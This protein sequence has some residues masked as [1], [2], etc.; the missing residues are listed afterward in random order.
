METSRESE[1]WS[2]KKE[3]D[4]GERQRAG[5]TGGP[6]SGIGAD[7]GHQC[8]MGGMGSHSGK[9]TAP[10]AG[11][12]ACHPLET[13]YRPPWWLLER[14]PPTQ[15]SRGRGGLG[16]SGSSPGDIVA[17]RWGY[18]DGGDEAPPPRPCRTAFYYWAAES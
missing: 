8:V 6:S 12:V 17:V 4:V 9:T 10:G 13:G 11:R 16:P 14:P 7:N 15:S 1:G 18:L 2:L 5:G 3:K